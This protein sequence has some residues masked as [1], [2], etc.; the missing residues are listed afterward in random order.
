[1]S[2]GPLKDQIIHTNEDTTR[3]QKTIR[4]HNKKYLE[5]TVGT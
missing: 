3:K 4:S 1:M 2:Y 5:R